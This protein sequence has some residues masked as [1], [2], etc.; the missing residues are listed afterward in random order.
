MF[1][2]SFDAA[3]DP[4]T[5]E[6][7][8]LTDAPSARRCEETVAELPLKRQPYRADLKTKL[9][10][11]WFKAPQLNGKVLSIVRPWSVRSNML[12]TTIMNAEIDIFAQCLSPSCQ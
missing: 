12:Q 11:F 9:Y 7:T 3:D 1:I 8:S 2:G 6:T 5:T 10:V 4:G